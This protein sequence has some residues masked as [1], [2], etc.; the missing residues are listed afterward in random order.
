MPE[1]DRPKCDERKK[2]ERE[3]AHAR[4]HVFAEEHPTHTDEGAVTFAACM[5]RLETRGYVE[6]RVRGKPPEGFPC[7]GRD[8]GAPPRLMGMGW[9]SRAARTRFRFK[10]SVDGSPAGLTIR[11]RRSS[12][13][14]KQASLPV[15]C[16]FRLID[17]VSS[18]RQARSSA[19]PEPAGTRRIG[20]SLACLLR[21]PV[22]FSG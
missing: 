5:M 19:C 10:P 13:E 15:R 16:P 11:P 1:P 14:P 12:A 9:F 3:R 8:R 6:G 21:P 7:A 18:V 2:K 4:P 22:S 17:R 20:V